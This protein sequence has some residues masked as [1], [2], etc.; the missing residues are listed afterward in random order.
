MKITNDTKIHHMGTYLKLDFWL[1]ASTDSSHVLMISDK[2]QVF[3]RVVKQITEDSL[4]FA[5]EKFCDVC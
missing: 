4:K 1:L 2:F 5:E 3:L